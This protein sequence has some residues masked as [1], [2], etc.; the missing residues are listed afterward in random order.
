VFSNQNCLSIFEHL[1]PTVM[2]PL[3]LLRL[4]QV[5]LPQALESYWLPHRQRLIHHMQEFHTLVLRK[6]ELHK[7]VRSILVRMDH[8]LASGSSALEASVLAA[9]A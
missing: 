8:T 3:A 5:S 1:Q 4:E 6:Q 9:S 7:L 2:V